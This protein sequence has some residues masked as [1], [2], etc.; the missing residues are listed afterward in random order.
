MLF[1]SPEPEQN[2]IH[3]IVYVAENRGPKLDQPMRPSDQIEILRRFAAW[4]AREK[5]PI[6]VIFVGEPLRRH[7]DDS[8]HGGV[9]I[10]YAPNAAALPTVVRKTL[11]ASRN[12]HRTVLVTARPDLEAQAAK[13]GCD[14]MRPTCFLKALDSTIGP[15]APPRKPVPVKPNEQAPAGPQSEPV[16]PTQE[17][18]S[19]EIGEMVDLL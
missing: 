7:P 12:G 5:N 16:K 13:A 18:E 6:T 2:E 9:R 1:R 19:S 17:P 15:A 3:S 8:E 14:T 10:R 4:A 11:R